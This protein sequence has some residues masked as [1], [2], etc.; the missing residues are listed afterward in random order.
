M[1][2]DYEN[3]RFFRELAMRKP[4]LTGMVDHRNFRVC[5]NEL[6]ELFRLGPTE[7]TVLLAGPTHAGKSQLL[8]YLASFL[9]TEI[10]RDAD[11]NDRPI[12]GCSA[13]TT[14][15][16][17]TAPKYVFQELLEDVGH[18]FFQIDPLSA[19][20]S[21]YKPAI[22]ADETYSLRALKGAFHSRNVIVVMIDDAH[23]LVR[24]KDEE[25]KASLLEA[26][27]GLVTPRT[28]LLL[29]GGYE[30]AT[31][32][33]AY[34]THFAERLLVVHMPR[35]GK[36]KGDRDEWRRVV[37]NFAESKALKFNPPTLLSDVADRLRF[38]SHGVIGILE[39][40]LIRAEAYAVARGERISLKVL[41][42]TRP[43]D[44]QWRATEADITTG[45]KLLGTR[46]GIIDVPM[47]TAPGASSGE[48]RPPD[49]HKRK[50]GNGIKK[51]RP[52]ERVPRRALSAVH[53]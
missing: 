43:V 35:Y 25:Y 52:F 18:P 30:L 51:P 12:I 36:S 28:T 5:L 15:Q 19:G 37:A 31:V 22:R 3:R 32:A 46:V 14:R 48:P 16:G 45:E 29:V 8:A 34:R 2:I 42:E 7:A 20:E 53:T 24:A 4:K 1:T 39:K 9:Q 27:K 10:F 33:L 40:R 49:T 50:R 11:E 47:H 26:L 21:L 23:Y 17:R 44:V 41:N 13:I 6:K 38:E